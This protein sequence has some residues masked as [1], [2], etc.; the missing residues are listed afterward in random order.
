MTD[1]YLRPIEENDTD[2]IVHWR[3][4]EYGRNHSLSKKLITPE[5]HRHHYKENVQTGRYRQFI[6]IRRDD[7]A[8][9][10]FYPIATVYLKDVDMENQRCELCVFTNCDNEWVEECQIEGIKQLIKKAFEEYGMHKVYSYVFC[11]FPEEV[12]R[13]EQV[14][15]RIEA[16]LENEAKEMD[17]NYTDIYRMSIFNDEDHK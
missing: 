1:I 4:S 17:G 13:L 6:V 16:K 12:K 10:A 15:L 14:G 8:G 9:V 3:N 11:K 5:S 7:T 2:L